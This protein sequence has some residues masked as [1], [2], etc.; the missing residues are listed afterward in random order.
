M[1]V[2]KKKDVLTFL[3]NHGGTE[4][5]LLACILTITSSFFPLAHTSSVSF[6][7]IRT[8]SS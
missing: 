3:E 6:S 5:G 8:I 1:K 7:E 2:K 4:T